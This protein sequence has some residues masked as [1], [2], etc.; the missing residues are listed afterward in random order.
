[1]TDYS[2]KNLKTLWFNSHYYRANLLWG[3]DTLRFRD[4]HKF[5]EKFKS[6]YLDEKGTSSKCDY[7][8][9]PVVDG[10][11]WG[12]ENDIAGLRFKTKGEEGIVDI[13][14]RDP[15]IDDGEKGKL[16]VS[17]PLETSDA[18]LD[19]V[20]NE[21]SITISMHTWKG[22]EWFLI[23]SPDNKKIPVTNIDRRQ[24]S[25]CFR[26]FSYSVFC[27][28]GEFMVDGNSYLKIVP[29]KGRICLYFTD[30]D[31]EE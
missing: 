26:D 5:D 7:Y 8:T 24:L 14:G 18:S 25:Y 16:K 1:M 15:V 21:G 6:D 13:A 4:I 23:L 3:N 22:N 12:S 9:L 29:E 11:A 17:W 30:N 20:F 19:L 31:Y 27:R 10:F 28:E 2:D